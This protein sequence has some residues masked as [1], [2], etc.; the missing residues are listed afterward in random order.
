MR[1]PRIIYWIIKNVTLLIVKDELRILVEPFVICSVNGR[2]KRRSHLIPR[3]YFVLLVSECF[4]SFMFP[5]F[6]W[7]W[8]KHLF[9]QIIIADIP[10][11]IY[12]KYSHTISKSDEL[13]LSYSIHWISRCNA[14]VDTTFPTARLA[15]A[16]CLLVDAH[17]HANDITW[18]RLATN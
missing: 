2:K 16:R 8:Q 12:P 14:D 18:H 13:S 4:L 1:F 3:P 11:L 5:V 6:C 15:Y 7:K 17:M 10:K 9:I